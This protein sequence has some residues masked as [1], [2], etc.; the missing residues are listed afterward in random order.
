LWIGL[1]TVHQIYYF[2]DEVNSFVVIDRLMN[3]LNLFDIEKLFHYHVYWENQ[4][5]V[6]Y[7]LKKNILLNY[8]TY[9]HFYTLVLDQK[10]GCFDLVTPFMMEEYDTIF[11]KINPDSYTCVLEL[12]LRLK[13]QQKLYYTPKIK[14]YLENHN[15]ETMKNLKPFIDNTIL[16]LDINKLVVSYLLY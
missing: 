6:R 7:L 13:K 4:N 10:W 3:S 2:I 9:P 5:L 11:D 16:P 8:P 1:I 14:K 15:L 12:G